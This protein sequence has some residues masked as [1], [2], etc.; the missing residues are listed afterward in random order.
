MIQLR[1]NIIENWKV[2]EDDKQKTIFIQRTFS[3]G[4]DVI[5]RVDKSDKGYVLT[6]SAESRTS[7]P[8]DTVIGVYPSFDQMINAIE[9]ECEEW[10]AYLNTD[11]KPNLGDFN[12]M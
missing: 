1:Q 7:G 10:D 12:A 4:T 9:K 3:D 6:S 2:I 8:N 5:L 11:M